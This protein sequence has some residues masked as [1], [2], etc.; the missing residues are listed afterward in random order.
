MKADEMVDAALSG[1]DQGELITI[2]SLP[3]MANW[4]AYGAAKTHAEPSPQ[5]ACGALPRRPHGL[6]VGLHAMSQSWWRGRT[7]ALSERISATLVT[8]AAVIRQAC[9]VLGHQPKALH[10]LAEGL[11]SDRL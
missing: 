2:P 5:N 11:P 8:A 10:V 7:N 9:R 6:G 4:Q 1:L 3:Y